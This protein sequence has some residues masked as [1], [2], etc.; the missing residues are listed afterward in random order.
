MLTLG[1]TGGSVVASM[2]NCSGVAVWVVVGLVGLGV[3]AATTYPL[4]FTLG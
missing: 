4:C 1:A 2:S 3:T